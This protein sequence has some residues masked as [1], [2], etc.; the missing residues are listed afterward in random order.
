MTCKKGILNV[1]KTEKKIY[2]TL[3]NHQH[4]LFT[5]YTVIVTDCTHR[6]SFLISNDKTKSRKD[7]L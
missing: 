3:Q 4:L 7:N 1:S 5:V 2:Y 6:F